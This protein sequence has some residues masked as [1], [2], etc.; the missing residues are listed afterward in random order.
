MDAYYFTIAVSIV[1]FLLI[2]SVC[3]LKIF[4]IVRRHQLQI[5]AQQQSLE[6]LNGEN[7]QRMKKSAINTF[8]YFM[9]M[10]LCHTPVFI[11]MSILVITPQHW[12]VAWIFTDTV[13]FMSSS[14]NPFLYCRRRRELRRAVVK[15]VRQI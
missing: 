12:T 8:I 13:A 6:S 7:N 11:A 10:I 5:H 1:I 2:S 9:A 15:T 3:Y 14:I 4:W